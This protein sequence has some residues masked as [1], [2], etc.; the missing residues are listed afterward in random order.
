[1]HVDALCWVGSMA[2]ALGK[3]SAFL[4][5]KEDQK[6]FSKHE[7]DVVRSIDG[8]HWSEPDQAYCDTTVVDGNRV[9]KVC[10][11]GYISLFPF[12]VG[13]MGPDHS[14][15]GAV[16][17]LIR[18]PEELWSPYGLRSL[19]SKDKYYGTDE[20]YWRG[21]VWIN[22]NYMV[23]QRLLVSILRLDPPFFQPKSIIAHSRIRSS[24]NSQA[25]TSKKC[26]KYTRSFG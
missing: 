7:A 11:K 10:H 19:S 15:L 9:E 8:I 24:L 25:H 5:E 22:I 17:D 26:A 14:H 2:V 3:I 18:G 1:M 12:L 13:L 16:L 6:M 23:M 21:P 20:N 4:G